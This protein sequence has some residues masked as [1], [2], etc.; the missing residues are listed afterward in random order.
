MNRMRPST[1]SVLQNPVLNGTT[2]RLSKDAFLRSISPRDSI[3]RPFAAL[4]LEVELVSDGLLIRREVDVAELRWQFAVVACVRYSVADDKSHDLVSVKVGIHIG[5]VSIAP[6]GDILAAILREI[7][8]DFPTLSDRC[9]ELSCIDW[10]QKEAGVG[11]DDFHVRSRA[12]GGLEVQFEGTRD[13]CVQ[14]AQSI[15]SGLYS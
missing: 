2:L 11:A 15:L 3:D 1:S 5:D 13:S 9:V 6:K 12:C 7:E 8:D 4:A 14:E 10:V